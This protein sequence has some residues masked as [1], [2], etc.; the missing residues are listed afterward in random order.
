MDE[1]KEDAMNC[2]GCNEL[3]TP[4]TISDV[5]GDCG[6]CGGRKCGGY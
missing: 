6:D 5:K 4:S 1:E 2:G 3:M